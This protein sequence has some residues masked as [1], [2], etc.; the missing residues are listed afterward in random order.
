MTTSYLC[1][2]A[3]NRGYAIN[4]SRCDWRSDSFKGGEVVY[5][6][7]CVV[8]NVMVVDFTSMY[9]SIMG[10]CGISPECL[11]YISP[12]MNGTDS[13]RYDSLG[14]GT[15]YIVRVDKTYICVVVYVT[16]ALGVKALESATIICE[17]CDIETSHIKDSNTVTAVV[18]RLIDRVMDTDV[19]TRIFVVS[20]EFVDSYE[21]VF[22]RGISHPGVNERQ[23]SLHA[24]L[25]LVT[26][27]YGWI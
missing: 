21:G 9:P 24:S 8:S 12:R 20:H 3:D 11:D 26:K 15:I 14:V 16:N 18:D 23:S 27:T 25:L 17:L 7:T 19:H 6:S 4:W 10:S 5:T 22:T 2:A 1:A 13:C